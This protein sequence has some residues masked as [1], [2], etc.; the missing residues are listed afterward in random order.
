MVVAVVEGAG[1]VPG[2]EARE[3]GR[4]SGGA[5]RLCG[6]GAGSVGVAPGSATLCS[7]V[8]CR[9]TRVATSWVAC[10]VRA[11]MSGGV[12]VVAPGGRRVGSVEC[13][14]VGPGNCGANG[15]DRGC[16]TGSGTGGRDVGGGIGNQD[17][18]RRRERPTW[19]VASAVASATRTRAAAQGAATQGAAAQGAAEQ[20][21]AVQVVGVRWLEP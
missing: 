17:E 20:G 5:G 21:A 14:P 15:S 10:W 9:N 7:K 8:N 12:A 3:G 11:C 16:G 1:P 6:W 4:V 13:V 19:A 2:N 18:R